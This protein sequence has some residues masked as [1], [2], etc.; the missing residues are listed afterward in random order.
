MQCE[1]GAFKPDA[2]NAT[3]CTKCPLGKA[4]EA[5]GQTFCY[6]R[7][8]PL[9][10]AASG[11]PLT[12]WLPQN[13]SAGLFTNQEGQGSCRSCAGGS[14]LPTAGQTVCLICEPGGS[15]R[16]TARGTP[17]PA[18][19]SHAETGYA[20]SDQALNCTACIP[21]R[22]AETGAKECRLCDPGFYLNAFNASV[23]EKCAQGKF[24]TDRGK[25][26]CLDCPAGAAT[27]SLGQAT[28]AVVRSRA[29]ARWPDTA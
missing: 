19:T 14:Y 6:V 16:Q 23:C 2:S 18:D 3:K 11:A 20:S 13:C 7:A 17:A 26:E 12:A 15:S 28:C 5:L 1:I 29:D 8:C 21:G 22:Y 25:V 27:T 9:A 10:P 4:Q 24:Q